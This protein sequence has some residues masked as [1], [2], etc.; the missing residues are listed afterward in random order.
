MKF[1]HED[2]FAVY[3]ECKTDHAFLQHDV[4]L[5]RLLMHRLYAKIR[6]VSQE[7]LDVWDY[8]GRKMMSKS[9]KW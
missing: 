5:I 1:G 8:D 9:A 6:L 4:W 7:R 3:D 2:G